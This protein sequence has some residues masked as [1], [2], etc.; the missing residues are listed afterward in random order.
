M[1]EQANDLVSGSC[2]AKLALLL[3]LLH[4]ESLAPEA[5]RGGVFRDMVH[6]LLH[7]G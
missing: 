3:M 4:H 7:L 2:L 5:T 1:K 6:K